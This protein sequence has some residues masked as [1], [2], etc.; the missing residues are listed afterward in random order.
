MSQLI[1]TFEDLF[2]DII[3]GENVEDPDKGETSVAKTMRLRSSG[4]VNLATGTKAVEVN[5]LDTQVLQYPKMMRQKRE[6]SS[7]GSMLQ[8]EALE[9]PVD[10]GHITPF[11]PKPPPNPLP[12]YHDSSQYCSY[13]Q[14]LGHPIEKCFRLHHKIQDLIDAKEIVH[15]FARKPNIIT[16]PLPNHNLGFSNHIHFIQTDFDNFDPNTLISRFTNPEAKPFALS[17][18]TS[19]D[20]PELILKE[21]EREENE[22]KTLIQAEKEFME[23]MFGQSKVESEDHLFSHTINSIDPDFTSICTAPYIHLA[24]PVTPMLEQPTIC[25]PIAIK[26]FNC[27]QQSQTPDNTYYPSYPNHKIV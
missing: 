13:H 24:P 14:S 17:T 3:Q 20:V 11:A 7:L 6:F 18:F 16:Y 25:T 19:E 22:E 9:R 23:L 26:V 4:E 1:H 5:A 2:L 15:P 12:P 8:T 27:L 21:M 10:A